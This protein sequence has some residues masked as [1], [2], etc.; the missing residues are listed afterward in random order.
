MTGLNVLHVILELDAAFHKTLSE[1]LTYM[2]A[3][4]QVVTVLSLSVF[5]K[6]PGNALRYMF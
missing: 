2:K 4:Y 6:C 5:K 3:Q 1:E